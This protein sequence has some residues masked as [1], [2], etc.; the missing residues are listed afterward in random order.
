MIEILVNMRYHLI[1]VNILFHG[2]PYHIGTSP[3]IYSANQWTGFY[4]IGG[5]AMKKI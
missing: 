1:R 4:V 3:L 2:G 5:S